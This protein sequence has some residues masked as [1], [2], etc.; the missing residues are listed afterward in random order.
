M[1]TAFVVGNLF[2]RVLRIAVA[3]AYFTTTWALVDILWERYLPASHSKRFFRSIG[4][5]LEGF[6]VLSFI[7]VV[8]L[9]LALIA[10]WSVS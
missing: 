8:L 6:T 3:V 9:G 7:A 10:L 1:S 2:L 4:L 5:P